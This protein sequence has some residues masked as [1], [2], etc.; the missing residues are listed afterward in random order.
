MSD[1]SAKVKKIV[2]DH[3]GVEEEKV[4]K[5]D[6]TRIKL[7]NFVANESGLWRKTDHFQAEKREN[8]EKVG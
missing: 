1:V 2:A 8:V 7:Y 3:L 6:W 5:I 4:T